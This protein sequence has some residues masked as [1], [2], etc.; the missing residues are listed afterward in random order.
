MRIPT[1]LT[2]AD[3]SNSGLFLIGM[4][5]SAGIIFYTLYSIRKI[6]E[7]G[8]RERTKREIAAY[9]AE[10]SLTADDAAKIL[11]S[12]TDDAERMIAD[13]VAWGTVKPEKAERLI[14]AIRDRRS[15]EAVIPPQAQTQ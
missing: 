4:L 5:V 14:R 15:G 12:D 8:A 13:G 7:K 3:I 10:G 6:L 2:L 9:V 11:S 1:V